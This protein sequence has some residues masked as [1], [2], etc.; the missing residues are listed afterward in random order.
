MLR[1][2]QVQECYDFVKWWTLVAEERNYDWGDTSLPY[3]DVKNADVLEPVSIFC[4]GLMDLDGAVSI[5]LVK[6]KL[7]LNL[8][9]IHHAQM[10]RNSTPALPQEIVDLVALKIGHDCVSRRQDVLLSQTRS[11]LIE[12]LKSQ[13]K[14]LIVAIT[15]YNEFYWPILFWSDESAHRS[16]RCILQSKSGGSVSSLVPFLHGLGGDTRLN[17]SPQVTQS[18]GNV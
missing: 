6:I 3:L 10:L 1:L 12:T 2:E 7:L 16:P 8:Q 5:V 11:L 15:S 18:Q 4:R 14:A 17:S 13:I 9:D